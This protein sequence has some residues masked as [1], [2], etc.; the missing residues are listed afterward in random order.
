MDLV[1]VQVAD[2]MVE[3]ARQAALWRGI[4]IGAAVASVVAV[5]AVVVILR[6]VLG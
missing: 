3:L 4:L 6:G 2:R 1:P 5:V